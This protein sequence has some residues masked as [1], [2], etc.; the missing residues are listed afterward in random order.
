MNELGSS[1]RARLVAAAAVGL[2]STAAL[3]LL[4][5]SLGR[6]AALRTVDDVVTVGVHAV[7]VVIL[8]WY[9]GTALVT[10]GCLLA[11]AAGSAWIGAERRLGTIGAPLMRRLL[12]AGTGAL[13]AATAVLAPAGATPNLDDAA[14]ADDLGWGAT[15]GEHAGP[16]GEPS[17]AAGAGST[18]DPTDPGAPDDDASAAIPTAGGA[19]GS[20]ESATYAVVPGDSLWAIAANHLD[21]EPDDAQVA[22]AWPLWFDANRDVVG[23]DPD[24]IHPGQVLRVPDHEPEEH[25]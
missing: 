23:D 17:P 3:W 25:A 13:V 4:V 2:G 1:I 11:R 21:G 9:L 18:T 7:G 15:D 8:L 16:E 14:I 10:A 12:V 22:E 19:A 20:R 24:L 6:V 5:A